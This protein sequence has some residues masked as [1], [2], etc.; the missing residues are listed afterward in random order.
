MAKFSVSGEHVKVPERALPGS[1]HSWYHSLLSHHV[2]TLNIEDD[3][4]SGQGGGNPL[5]SAQR[6][7]RPYYREEFALRLL[8]SLNYLSFKAWIMSHPI[9]KGCRY[10]NTLI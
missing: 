6:H 7:R 2:A 10:L 5:K 1:S 3:T 4:G 9:Y 8:F